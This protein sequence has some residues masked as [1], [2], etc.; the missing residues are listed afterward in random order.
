MQIC[1]RSLQ[2]LPSF[3]RDLVALL[4]EDS[5]AALTG[6]L[7]GR[8][9]LRV[10]NQQRHQIARKARQGLQAA[11]ADL[12]CALRPVVAQRHDPDRHRLRMPARR[13][14]GQHAH[15]HCRLDHAAG[16]FEVADLDAQPQAAVQAMADL[17][18]ERMDRARLVQADVVQRQRV[19]KVD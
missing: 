11:N 15:A 7:G 18:Q 1:V 19:G 12:H 8:R 14:L 17:A 10:F 5:K 4:V 6:S 9:G 13:R 2:A 3:A 16:G